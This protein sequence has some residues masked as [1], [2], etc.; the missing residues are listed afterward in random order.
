MTPEQWNTLQTCGR[1][2]EMSSTP[3]A[4]IVDS[5]WIPGLLGI[6]TLDY[7][8]I[9]D[10]FL[11]ANLAIERRFPDVIFIPGF[12]GEVGM[13]AE[14]SGFGC[15]VSLFRDK[16]P[17]VYALFS[18]MADLP[19]VSMPNPRTDGFMPMILNYY[20]HLE[21]RVTD[22]GQLIKIVAARGP[23]TVAT[24]LMGVSNFLLALKINPG[25]THRLLR[26]TTTLVRDWLEA[27]VEALRAAEGVLVL[28]DIA[29]FISPRDY[30]QFAHPYLKEVFDY[31]P[32]FL[33]LFHND[34]DNPAS[35]P[36]LKELGIHIFNFTHLQPLA[37]VRQ[38]VGPGSA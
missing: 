21:P 35:F 10:V 7:L 11:Q 25:A 18:D 28:D 12:W 29:G 2:E 17:V 5:P 27:Q 24:H 38:L 4:L 6:S 36:F 9:P 33:K 34:T 23:L 32:G 15:K 26:I 31:F 37:K 1:G 8:T 30:R 3:V 22:A 14:P 20:R 13:A 19:Q 16:T